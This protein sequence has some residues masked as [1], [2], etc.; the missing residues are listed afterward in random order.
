MYTVRDGCVH[1][2]AKTQHARCNAV[3]LFSTQPEL[4]LSPIDSTQFVNS[5]SPN[6]HYCINQSV[7]LIL[8]STNPVAQNSQNA[9]QKSNWERNYLAICGPILHRHRFEVIIL[10]EPNRFFLFS[11]SSLFIFQRQFLS[12]WLLFVDII[13]VVFRICCVL[14][15]LLYDN[16]ELINKTPQ[17]NQVAANIN[18]PKANWLEWNLWSHLIKFKS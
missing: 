1:Y 7:K 13:Y 3:N 12:A 2:Q 11:Y 6:H 5:I 18:W 4:L 14:C 15:V 16:H 17:W 9:N 8:M 10:T